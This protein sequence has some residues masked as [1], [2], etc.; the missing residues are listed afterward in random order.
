MGEGGGKGIYLLLNK[1]RKEM[2][3]LNIMKRKAKCIGMLYIIFAI[4]VVIVGEYK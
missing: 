3:N 1:I 4:L 2:E